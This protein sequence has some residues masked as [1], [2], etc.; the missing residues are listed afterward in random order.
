MLNDNRHQ[1][2]WPATLMACAALALWFGAKREWH[3]L[4]MYGMIHADAQGYYGYL[5]AIFI[6]RSFDW[7][8]VVDSYSSVYFGDGAPDFTVMTDHGPVNKYY[9]GTAVLMLPFF[10]LSCLAAWAMD[11]PVDGYAIPFHVGMM[12]SALFYALAGLWC[13]GQYLRAK[14]FSWP[15]ICA[16]VWGVFAGTGL[17]FYTVMEPAMSHVYS[18]FLFS[19]FILLAHRAI[20]HPV[21]S[22]VMLLAAVLAL[23]ALVRPTNVVIVLSMPFIAGGFRPFAVFVSDVFANRSTFIPALA[24]GLSIVSMQLALYMLQVGRP[25]VW[26]YSGE[27]FDFLDPEI[28]NVLFSYKKGLFVYYP[29]TLIASLGLVAMFIKLRTAAL[30]IF[31]FLGVSVY[32]ISSW[33]AWFYGASFGMRAMVEYL[34]FFMVLMAHLFQ[35]VPIGLRS[36]VMVLSF[37]TV[38]LNLVQT[39]QYNKFIL[40][41]LAM[42]ADRYWQ[43]F[44]KTDAR[45][46]GI[47][48]RTAS[49]EELPAKDSIVHRFVLQND[50][51]QNQARWGNQGRSDRQSFGGQFSCMMEGNSQYGNTLIIPWGELGPEGKKV[52]LAT[53]I[54]R[55]ETARPALILA[56][57]VADGERYYAHNYLYCSEQ[58]NEKDEWCAVRII[59]ELPTAE[60]P[61]HHFVIYPYTTGTDTLF[62]DDIRYE[63]LT[64]KE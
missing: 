13:M 37:L 53:F 62:V 35:A 45:Y 28:L 55:S 25:I 6:E 64:V 44:L 23:I 32:I 15:V 39:Y 3:N 49:N 22:R 51:E 59:A 19:L 24:L 8:Q 58:V 63:F 2:L 48:Y 5:V 26:S 38:P 1:W 47:F 57:S 52:L 7:Q 46:E 17:F 12:L 34:P 60:S 61:D 14:G 29:W 11:Y 41:W 10:L 40:H 33:W 27:G 30:W 16:V 50:M 18:F 36:G 54:V 42:D 21:R 43:V 31:V 9:A 20:A 4:A 56:Y